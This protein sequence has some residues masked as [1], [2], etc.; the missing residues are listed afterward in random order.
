M[1]LGYGSFGG[2]EGGE[3]FG[4]GCF[5]ADHTTSSLGRGRKVGC[6]IG[7]VEKKLRT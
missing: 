6:H 4:E 2:G 7:G 5:A 1:G 3:V